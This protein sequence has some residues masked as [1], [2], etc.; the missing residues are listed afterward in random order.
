MIHHLSSTDYISFIL[1]RSIVTSCKLGYQELQKDALSP[2]HIHS[3]CQ[4]IAVRLKETLIK[5]NYIFVISNAN[6]FSLCRNGFYYSYWFRNSLLSSNVVDTE[7]GSDIY[8][9]RFVIFCHIY[10]IYTK[11]NSNFTIFCITDIFYLLL[12]QITLYD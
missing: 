5:I 12:I 7:I 3:L 8:M 1:N 9:Y 2:R 10:I 4:L 6:L 11:S